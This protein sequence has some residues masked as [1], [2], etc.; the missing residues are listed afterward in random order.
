VTTSLAV[1]TRMVDVDPVKQV[2]TTRLETRNVFP[3]N[4]TISGMK[5]N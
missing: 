4:S 3:Q 5:G 1:N 2:F